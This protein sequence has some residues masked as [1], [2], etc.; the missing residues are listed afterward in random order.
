[1][2]RHWDFFANKDIS[3]KLI[4]R[5]IALKHNMDIQSKY[6]AFN[7][8]IVLL[9]G[10]LCGFPYGLAINKK[11]EELIRAWKLAHGSLVL[12]GTLSLAIAGCMNFI[13]F[14]EIYKLTVSFSY[15]A[16][17][18]CFSI[19][20]LLEPFW[21]VRGLKWSTRSEFKEKNNFIFNFNSL[22]VVTSL[23]GTIGL[24]LGIWTTF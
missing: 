8:A 7:G 19:A 21:R 9:M 11:D 12:G 10:L 23:I 14:E 13:A 22:G 6:L 2:E 17:G 15:I 1:M 24:I 5:N 20:L 4:K 3:S 16:S 18:Y